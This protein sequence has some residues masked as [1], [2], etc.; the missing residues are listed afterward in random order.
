MLIYKINR[1]KEVYKE[2]METS[3]NQVKFFVEIYREELAAEKYCEEYELMSG[4]ASL[5]SRA[6]LYR[7]M[8]YKK[9]HI[10]KNGTIRKI[11]Q[12]IWG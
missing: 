11:M 9:N 7:I 4:Y 2:A 5:G 12:V 10:W 1:I 3:R 8:F 6:K